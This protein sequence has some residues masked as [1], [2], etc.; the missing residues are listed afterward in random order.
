MEKKIKKVAVLGAGVM[1]AQIA[2]HLANA[3]IPSYLFDM[4]KELAEKG[5]DVLTSL[6]PKPLYKPKNLELVTPCTYDD[7]IEKIAEVDWVLEAVVERLDIKEKIY[8]KLLPHLKK[9]AILTSN[10][11]GIPLKDLTKN[12][13]DDVKKRFMITHF[14]NPPRYMQLLELVRGNETTDGTY[15]TMIDFGESMLGK[16]I[17]HA[18]DTPNFI[19]NRIGVYGMMVAINLAKEHGLTVEEVDKL[20]GPISGR[21]KSATFRT[22][23]VVGLDTLKNVSLTTY[24]KALEDEE[25]DIFQI[26]SILENLIDT[27]RLGQKTKS[28]FYKKNEDR[29]IHSVDLKTGE[30]GPMNTVRFDC[31]RV[32][33]DRQNL[34]DKVKALCNGE[35]R[36]SKYFWEITARML[37]YS[38]NRVPEISDDIINIDN[39]M[40]W[41]FGWEAGPF[42]FWDMLGIKKTTD[43]MKSEGKTVP[44]WILGMLES[45]RE[46]FYEIGNGSKTFWCPTK[47]S[48]VT[49]DES[50]KIFNISL[51]KTQK[52]TIIKKDLSASLIDLGDGV[53][54]VEFHSILQPTLHPID[55][56]YIEM[57]NLAVE[58]MDK[59]DYKAMVLGHQGANFCAGANLNLLLELSKNNQWEALDFAV[60]T[61]Q[62]MTQRI[63]FSSAPIVAAPFQ[64]TLGGGVEIVQPAA[65]RVAA[66]ET[67]MGLVEVGVG[68]IPGGGGNLRM[69][70]NAMDGG[71]GRMGA[72]QK[73]QKTFETVGFAKIA[74]S[75][76]EAKHLGYLKKD[77]TIILNRSHQI[78]AAKNKA[79]DLAKDYTPPT[80]RE[81]L[82]LP[83][84]GGRTAMA[85]A[86]K[87]FKM[88]GKISDHD[89]K[90]GEKLAYV[91]TGGDK[92]GLTK[93][94]DEQYILDIER[95][96]FVSLAGEKLTQDRIKYMLKKGRPLRN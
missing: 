63:R 73:I 33:K 20:T 86:L 59:G 8:Q 80:Y 19:G 29:S 15:E 81:D 72:F 34:A 40:K 27:G 54:N 50:S 76:D 31:F 28:G 67:Y 32:A 45:G 64:L 56:S 18:K 58:M 61:M 2:G 6:K 87:G 78:Q 49:I 55:S 41:G 10:T 11:S 25:R 39:A 77:D 21:P 51:H 37:I 69:I 94:V 9:E 1:G 4:N 52:N 82:K 89:Q 71:T 90:I 74:T 16:G 46:T 93:S 47:K 65:H 66:A 38:A 13:P 17:V 3:G 44:S 62:D 48:E 7:H 83:G 84:A 70:L 92:A 88:Q 79:I 60:K 14:F 26:P 12:L 57:I 85:M 24:D 42:E 30:Y 95:E 75:A 23:D 96:A 35:D 5:K 91:L 53:L 22:A 68:L 43:R 36:G